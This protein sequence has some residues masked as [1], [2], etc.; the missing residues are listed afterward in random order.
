[1]DIGLTV[2]TV[3]SITAVTLTQHHF[4]FVMPHP[5]VLVSDYALADGPT[6]P[7]APKLLTTTTT[8]LPSPER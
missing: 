7:D 6:S 2:A 4:D 5:T 3:V 8:V 1:M